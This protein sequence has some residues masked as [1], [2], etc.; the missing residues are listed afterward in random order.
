MNNFK[1]LD[2]VAILNA[3]PGKNLTAGQVGTIV[4]KL[5]DDCYE[6]EFAGNNGETYETAAI[7]SHNLLLLH[8]EIETA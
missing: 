5:E 7:N 6:V 1:I 2:V 8:Y 3:V 4:E